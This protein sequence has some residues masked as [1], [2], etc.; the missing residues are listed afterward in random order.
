[1]EKRQVLQ[2]ANDREIVR[3]GDT[4]R[5]PSG[6]STLAVHQL[7]RHLEAVGFAQAPR[8]LGLDEDG[9]ETLTYVPGRSGADGWAMV[10]KDRGLTAAARLLRAYHDAVRDFRP[11]PGT[12]WSY[13]DEPLQDG[14]IV[15]HG[16]FYPCNLVWRRGQ[17]VGIIDWEYAGPGTIIDDIAYA[18]E[19]VTPF[20][21]DEMAVRWLGYD[22]PPDRRRRMETFCAAY[23]LTTVNDLMDQVVRRQRLTLER[24]RLIAERG[25]EPHVTWVAKGYLDQLEARAA[26]SER[27]RS[28]FE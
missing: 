15:C 20:R 28:L 6:P 25:I 10:V 3:I 22:Q 24:V 19:Y 9:R 18:L 27:H 14:Q 7:L 2:T 23:G 4:V 17:P 16:D 8:A 21:D 12:S 26:W 11:A 5:R 1:M 13:T